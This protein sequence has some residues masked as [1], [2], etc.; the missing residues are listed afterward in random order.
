MEDGSGQVDGSRWLRGAHIYTQVRVKSELGAKYGV[1]SFAAQSSR[2]TRRPAR[3]CYARIRWKGRARQLG[4][5]RQS[6]AAR[7][8]LTGR[9]RQSARATFPKLGRVGKELLDGPKA[10]EVARSGF[11]LLFYFFY[12]ISNPKYSKPNSNFYF[13]FKSILQI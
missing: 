5:T 6:P 9:A 7:E 10:Q 8:W 11:C 2:R 1:A 4:P 3:F 12:S 13:K